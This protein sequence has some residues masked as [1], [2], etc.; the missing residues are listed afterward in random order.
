VDQRRFSTRLVCRLRERK[1]GNELAQSH[2]RRCTHARN[3]T[4]SRQRKPVPPAGLP[5]YHRVL[6]LPHRSSYIVY[7][8]FF[9]SAFFCFLCYGFFCFDGQPTIFLDAFEFLELLVSSSASH[10]PLFYSNLLFAWIGL[11]VLKFSSLSSFSSLFLSILYGSFLSSPP[12]KLL[13]RRYFSSL[14]ALYCI[15]R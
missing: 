1:L 10:F 6:F 9:P 11:R 12:L 14:G 8:L 4:L 7:P 15:L 3:P 13:N 5:V 2:H